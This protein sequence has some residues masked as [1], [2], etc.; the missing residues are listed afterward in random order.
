MKFVKITT[1][2]GF[3]FKASLADY[4]TSLC[5]FSDE[6]NIS[7][8]PDSGWNIRIAFSPNYAFK[9]SNGTNGLITIK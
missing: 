2:Y 1:A 6:V 4:K 5:F 8:N 9:I 7:K 3:F